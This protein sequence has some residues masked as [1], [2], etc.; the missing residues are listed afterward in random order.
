LPELLVGANWNDLFRRKLTFLHR[1]PNGKSWSI[2]ATPSEANLRELAVPD[3]EQEC[4]RS[5][6]DFHH[7]TEVASARLK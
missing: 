6:P 3:Q 7:K 2:T 4:L 5:E 1:H